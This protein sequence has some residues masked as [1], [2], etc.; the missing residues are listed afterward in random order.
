MGSAAPQ[1]DQLAR[2]IDV[3]W[4]EKKGKQQILSFV[5]I[6]LNRSAFRRP[7]LMERLSKL[8]ISIFVV[9]LVVVVVVLV[10]KDSSSN[11]ANSYVNGTANET[12]ELQTGAFGGHAPIRSGI[13][14]DQK[15][16]ARPTW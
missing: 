7:Q 16:K 11:G 15:G 13:G 9:V 14:V 4:F 12:Q 6:R 10:G 5:P 2:L 1:T 8:L 3:L